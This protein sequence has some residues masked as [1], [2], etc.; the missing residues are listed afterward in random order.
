MYSTNEDEHRLDE[1][2]ASWEKYMDVKGGHRMNFIYLPGND[3]YKKNRLHRR[4]WYR[5]VTTLAAIVVFCTVYALILPALTM[6][7]TCQ[8]EEHTHTIECYSKVSSVTNEEENGT[9]TLTCTNTKEAHVHTPLCYGEWTLECETAEHV[10]TMMCYQTETDE[11]EQPAAIA[12]DSTNETQEE[13]EESLESKETIEPLQVNDYIKDAT[14][15]YRVGEQEKWIEITE[16]TKDIPANA[17]FRLEVKYKDVPIEQLSA[18]KN[19]MTYELPALFQQV[20]TNGTIVDGN[21]TAGTITADGNRITL[22]FDETWINDQKKSGSTVIKGDFYVE[23]QVDLSKI[24]T[25]GEET[26]KIGDVTIKLDFE[27]DYLAKHG[28]VEIEKEIISEGGKVEET[29]DGEFLTYQLTV[30]AGEDGCPEVTVRDAFDANKAYVDQYVVGSM[31]PSKGSAIMDSTE[32]N[33]PGTLVWTIGDMG[34]SETQTLQ[35]RVKL[36]DSY[37]GV[38]GKGNLSNLATVYSKTYERAED[39]ATFEPKAKATMSKEG[40]E[41]VRDEENG[42]WNIHYTIWLHADKDNSY[43]L[44]NV[45]VIDGLDGRPDGANVTEEKYREYLSY[46]EDSFKLYAGGSKNQNGTTGLEELKNQGELELLVDE[47][48]KGNA[49]R[50]IA[51]DLK[52]GESKTLVYTVHVDE[53]VLVAAG[54]EAFALKNRVYFYTDYT[55]PSDGGNQRLES[56]HTTK[57]LSQKHWSRKMVGEE[58]KESTTIQMDSGSFPV[59]AGSYKYQIVANEAGDWDL[60]SATMSDHL[61]SGH[62]EY[63]GYVRVDAYN[64]TNGKEFSSD[65]VAVAGLEKNVPNKTVWI[66]IDQATS[67]SFTPEQIG[68]TDKNCAYLLTYYAKPVCTDGVSTVLVA[69]E[70]QLTGTVGYGDKTYTLVGITVEASVEVEGSNFF[71]ARKKFWYYDKLRAE[72]G[73]FKNG[74]LYWG[75]EVAAD[76]ITAGTQLRDICVTGQGTTAQYLRG[77]SFVGA[78]LGNVEDITSYEDLSALQSDKTLQ[79]LTAAREEGLGAND[80]DC[81]YSISNSEMII[82]L[83]KEM[84]LAGKKLYVVVKTEPDKLPESKTDFKVFQNKLEYREEGTA[85]GWIEQ[86]TATNTIYGHENI[87]KNLGKV[88]TKEDG[89]ITEISS[90]DDASAVEWESLE[91]GTY[92]SWQIRINHIPTLNGNFRFLEELPKGMEIAYVRLDRLGTKAQNTS[93]A[94]AEMAN[95]EEGWEKHTYLAKPD[96]RTSIYYT[97]GQQV[98]WQ[99]NDV[100]AESTWGQGEGVVEL[101]VVCKVTDESVLLGGKEQTF[102]N[103]VS[104]Q[105]EEGTLLGTDTDSVA[106]Q[107]KTLSKVGTYDKKVNGGRYP[108]EITIN[109]LGEDLIKGSDTICLV[110]EY[111]EILT[112]DTTS[113]RV[114]NTKTGEEIKNWTSAIDGQKLTL[115]LPDYLPLTITYEAMINAKPGEEVNI[116]NKAY[117]YGYETSEGSSVKDEQFSYAVGGSVGADTTPRVTIIK[118]NQHNNQELLK[119]AEFQLQEGLVVNGEFHAKEE[120]I[121]LSGSTNENGKLVFG[122]NGNLKYNTIYQLKETKAPAGY[123]LDAAPHTF[124]VV[125]KEQAEDFQVPEGVTAYYDGANYTYLAYNHRGEI[126]V[127]KQFQNAGGESIEQVTGTYTF[128]IFE[129]ADAKQPFQKVTITY[130][131]GV[132]TSTEKTAKF[133]NLPLKDE[134]GNKKTYYVYEL[135]DYGNPIKGGDAKVSGIPFTVSYDQTEIVLNTEVAWTGTVTVTNQLNYPELPATGGMG[136]IHIWLLGGTLLLCAGWIFLWQKKKLNN[137]C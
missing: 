28:T 136:R 48:G 99:L 60:S 76:T 68:M 98:L 61:K 75:L 125:K 55:R 5:G 11:E 77:A 52:P 66:K 9:E 20:Q 29:E 92:A 24:P 46:V 49:F 32:N 10:H 122:A 87:I 104:I 115:T 129:T 71:E 74:S 109:E 132:D 107:K 31:E 44:E 105:T 4:R 16:T 123:V 53:G 95:L 118:M 43:T 124:V 15:F 54:N 83:Q 119:G 62:M 117:W 84:K 14:L 108:F 89:K 35:Y 41:F 85:S 78:Y 94:F 6:E 19:Q 127:K 67:F 38:Q 13:Q 7:L 90:T 82:T 100:K 50:Y 96:G 65:E 97:N 22:T 135:D 128:G 27:D 21:T 8:Q 3:K 114:T 106:I 113:I 81:V 58:L 102:E 112:L 133:T 121:T 33:P 116:Q 73:D 1:Y 101:Q 93:V 36:K 26:I 47:N 111:C 103:K 137:R 110:D 39:S 59:P 40:A 120:G 64:L 131:N 51:G 56:Y 18:A 30:T 25:D 80:A 134:A 130:E 126:L 63:V 37:T 69:N 23:A 88:F 2:M 86:N 42:G 72:S 12:E 57:T 91:N 34:K 79:A 45:Y 70:F 17:S